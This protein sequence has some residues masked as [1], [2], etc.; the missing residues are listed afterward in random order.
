[1]QDAGIEEDCKKTVQETIEGL[2]GIDII[3]ANAV[4]IPTVF[5]QQC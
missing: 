3:I 5:T 2:G 1:M 4:C